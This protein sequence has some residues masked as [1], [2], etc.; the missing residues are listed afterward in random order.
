MPGRGTRQPRAQSILIFLGEL[1]LPAARLGMTTSKHH[2]MKHS[3]LPALA[4]G[5][6]LVLALPLH[7]GR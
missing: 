4:L 6:G 7:A 2:S 5:L 1:R 3:I